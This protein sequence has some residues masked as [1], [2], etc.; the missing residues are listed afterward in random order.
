M[1]AIDGDDKLAAADDDS[2]ALACDIS[3]KRAPREIFERGVDELCRGSLADENGRGGLIGGF[4]GV[5]DPGF[6]GVS[7]PVAAG[8]SS[9]DVGAVVSYTIGSG[10]ASGFASSADGSSTGLGSLV[11]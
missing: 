10:S 7:G 1:S 2:D 3:T 5:S 4:V 11:C 8:G 6:V 9:T